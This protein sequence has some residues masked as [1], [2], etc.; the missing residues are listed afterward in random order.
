M[1]ESRTTEVDEMDSPPAGQQREEDINES[2]DERHI[3]ADKIQVELK[4]TKEMASP[5]KPALSCAQNASRSASPYSSSARE[6][7][8]SPAQ[9][10]SAKVARPNKVPHSVF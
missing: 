6:P 4:R 7:P 5:V 10:P 9:E 8:P 2:G 3:T 1:N